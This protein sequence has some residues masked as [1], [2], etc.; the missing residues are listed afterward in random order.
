MS[1]AD[2]LNATRP[3]R[4]FSGTCLRK[5]SAAWRAAARRDGAT[6]VDC[7]EPE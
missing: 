7:I 3:T 1:R 2:W 6:S 5:F 4:T